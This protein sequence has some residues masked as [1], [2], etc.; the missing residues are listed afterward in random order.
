MLAL[1]T[2]SMICELGVVAVTL[3]QLL[4]TR[5]EHEPSGSESESQSEAMGTVIASLASTLAVFLLTLIGAGSAASGAK[6]VVSRASAA[7]AS[8]LNRSRQSS[9]NGGVGKIVP[10]SP[11][12]KDGTPEA[13]AEEE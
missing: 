9:G 2:V 12:N 4:S 10:V 8:L 7:G 3:L 5:D 11:S 6:L 13:G 1:N